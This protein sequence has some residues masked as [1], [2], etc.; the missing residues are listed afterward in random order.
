M[1][2]DGGTG[3]LERLRRRTG[4][5]NRRIECRNVDGNGGGTV[6]AGANDF[7]EVGFT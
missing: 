6:L 5:G 2:G 7:L 3:G 4:M 1:G